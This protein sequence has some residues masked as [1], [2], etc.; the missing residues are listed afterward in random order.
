MSLPAD[1]CV[2]KTTNNI[3]GRKNVYQNAIF[4]LGETETRRKECEGVGVR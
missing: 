2:T 1:G 3:G 4:R